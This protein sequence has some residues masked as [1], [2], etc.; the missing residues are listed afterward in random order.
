MNNAWTISKAGWLPGLALSAALHL[1]TLAVL[2]RLTTPALPPEPPRSPELAA[3]ESVVEIDIRNFLSPRHSATPPPREPVEPD[4]EPEPE[5][6]AEPESPIEEEK[7]REEAALVQP[8]PLPDPET[9][10]A[11]EN[12]EETPTP[13]V[14]SAPAEVAT[15]DPPPPEEPSQKVEAPVEPPD[16]PP[17]ETVVLEPESLPDEEESGPVASTRA[18]VPTGAVLREDTLELTYPRRCHRRGHEGRVMLEIELDREGRVLSVTSKSAPGICPR[19]VQAAI[20]AAR[21]ARFQPARQ[22][23]E[24]VASRVLQPVDFVHPDGS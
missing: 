18:G 9:P 21:K 13:P 5:L 7:A 23:D 3:G 10:P 17:R 6:T 1:G 20:E 2:A 11:P 12:I 22:G 8:A 19:L 4:P 24:P 14:E 16:S 15:V